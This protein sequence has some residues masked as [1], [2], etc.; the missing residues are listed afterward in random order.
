MTL[1]AVPLEEL[2]QVNRLQQSYW[3]MGGN[4]RERLNIRQLEQDE[5]LIETALAFAARARQMGQLA[6]K[7]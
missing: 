2:R 4:D 3:C 6:V 5:Q 7:G 1:A